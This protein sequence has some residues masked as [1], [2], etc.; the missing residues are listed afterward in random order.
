MDIGDKVDLRRIVNYR[1]IQDKPSRWIYV[2]GKANLRRV[3]DD[4]GEAARGG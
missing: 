2:G 3:E 1:L 4:K